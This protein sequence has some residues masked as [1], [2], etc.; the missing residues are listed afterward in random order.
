[1]PLDSRPRSRFGLVSFLDKFIRRDHRCE[2]GGGSKGNG[3]QNRAGLLNLA[4]LAVS[5]H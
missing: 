1:M 2:A 5:Q 4:A 3:Q